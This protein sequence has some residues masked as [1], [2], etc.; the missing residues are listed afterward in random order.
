MTKRRSKAVRKKAA[1]RDLQVEEFESRDLGDDIRT[2]GGLR[3]GLA[4]HDPQD[5]PAALA[6]QP[7]REVGIQ[8]HD[9]LERPQLVRRH[10]QSPRVGRSLPA[11]Y[12]THRGRRGLRKIV[13][14]DL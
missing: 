1:K 13:L 4:F 11:H 14:S 8:P 2:A 12:L 9:A 5:L 6:Q 3:A 7:P 10:G